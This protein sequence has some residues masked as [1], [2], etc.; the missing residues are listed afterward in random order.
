MA[1][2]MMPR[3][4][5][6][7]FPHGGTCTLAHPGIFLDTPVAFPTCRRLFPIEEGIQDRVAVAI[8]VR[9]FDLDVTLQ[10]DGEHLHVGMWFEEICTSEV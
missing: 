8:R 5:F 2:V 10:S 6:D 4:R 1:L 9:D 3:R 7:Y